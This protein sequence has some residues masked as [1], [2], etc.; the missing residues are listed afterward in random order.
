MSACEGSEETDEGVNGQG[1]VNQKIFVRF[2][3]MSL[4]LSSV[5]YSRC[6]EHQHT[7]GYPLHNQH[8][9]SLTVKKPTHYFILT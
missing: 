2:A 7:S 6:N 4:K 3:G 5:C 9:E 8:S 1:D